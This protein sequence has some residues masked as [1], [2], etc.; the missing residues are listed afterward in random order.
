MATF[1][2]VV[3]YITFI[4][5]GLPDSL[6]GS[7]WS[8][9]RQ[10][11]GMKLSAAGIISMTI[12]AGTILSS[13]MSERIIRRFRTGPVTAVSVLAT[14]T[15]LL[16][17]SLA[18]SFWWLVAL[19]VPLGLGAGAVDVGLN[20][21]VAV[22]YKP[23]HMSWLHCFW[24][25]GA[26]S[27]PLI[28]AQFI[29]QDSG[30]RGGYRAISIIQFCLVAVLFFTL[31]LWKRRE[32]ADENGAIESVDST[33]AVY[34][35]PALRIPGL[36][37]A[38]LA[39]FFYCG[40]EQATGVWGGSYLV[41]AKGLSPA[42]AARWVSLFFIGITVGRLITGF[43]TMRFSSLQ[44]IRVGQLTVLAGAAVL[45]LPLPVEFSLAGLVLMGLGCA[46]VFPCMIHETPNR[47]G[48]AQSSKTMGIQMAAAYVG[49][50][51]LPPALGYVAAGA[52]IRIFPATL[53]LFGIGML[54]ACERLNRVVKR[55]PDASAQNL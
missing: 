25:V 21:Y 41:E 2:L 43:V 50:T 52:G 18:P 5:L 49:N 35:G 47:F 40:V 27:G 15:A 24:G 1:F 34:S 7:A 55:K 42:S 30:W 37:M 13:L 33:D 44:L 32:A 39:F 12:S 46:P 45:A 4:S 3:I 14:A 28:M 22:H 51:F 29:Q 10:D 48:T 54:L 26:F 8:V 9:M 16:G 20:N 36:I 17:F 53:L 31:P 6:L 38:M 11:L 23:H 19:A